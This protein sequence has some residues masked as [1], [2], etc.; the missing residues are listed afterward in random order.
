[1]SGTTHEHTRRLAIRRGMD[2]FDAYQEVYLGS[3]IDLITGTSN[4]DSARDSNESHDEPGSNGHRTSG[5]ELGPFPT[6]ALGNEGP[7]SQSVTHVYGTRRHAGHADVRGF[8]VRP[9][10]NNPFARPLYIPVHAVHSISMDR[11]IVDVRGSDIPPEWRNR[12]A[13]ER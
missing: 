8:V 5:E 11:I 13:F 9:G 6:I 1:M 4:D 7:L 3:V 2:V 12:R 10:R